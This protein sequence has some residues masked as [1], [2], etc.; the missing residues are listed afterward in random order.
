[1]PSSPNAPLLS[2][3]NLN[4]SFDRHGETVQAVAGV[5]FTLHKG[6]SLG[7]VGESGSGKSVSVMSL[8]G[9]NRRNGTVTGEAVFDGRDLLKLGEEDLRKVRGKDISMVFQDPMSSLNPTYRIGRQL[10]EPPI[11]HRLTQGKGA[12]EKALK[13]L[14]QVGIPEFGS[15]FRDYPFQFSGGMRQRVM[16]A[17]AMT[18]DPQLLIADEPTTALDVTV[19]SQIL[20]LMQDMKAETGMSIIMITHDFTMATNFCDKILV[21]YAG[22]VMESA[23]T[24]AFLTD[25]RHPYSQGL[26]GSV[27]DIDSDAMTLNPI[28]GSPPNLTRLPPGCRFSPRCPLATDLCRQ[29]EPSLVAVGENHFAACHYAEQGAPRG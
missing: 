25:P 21:L 16:I 7:I 1:M 4:V 20:N 22:R 6:E 26:L 13:L 24:A 27:L 15:R 10:M 29:S 11:W 2:V 8:L 5:S 28:P 18:C 14:K 23:P 19:R 3:N 17:M 9:L 12:R